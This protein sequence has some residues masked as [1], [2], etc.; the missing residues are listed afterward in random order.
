M[1]ENLYSCSI[2]LQAWST[3]IVPKIL[4]RCGHTI[5]EACLN[6]ILNNPEPK[7]PFDS[8]IFQQQ[9]SYQTNYYT[10]KACWSEN[11]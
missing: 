5:C 6:K 9:D 10:Q 7:C 4:P 1:H 3:E 11:S 2:C 8:T